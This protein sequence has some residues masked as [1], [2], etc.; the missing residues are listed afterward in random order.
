MNLPGFI[1]EAAFFPLGPH[2]QKPLD[3][4]RLDTNG[5][6]TAQMNYQCKDNG[7]CRCHGTWDCMDMQQSGKCDGKRRACHSN[8]TC[9]C[10]P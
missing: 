6:V 5:M 7:E 2:S 3:R 9:V 4:E 1:T 10:Y 8:G